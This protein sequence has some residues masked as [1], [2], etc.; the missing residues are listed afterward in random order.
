MYK[1]HED[2]NL[3]SHMSYMWRDSDKIRTAS[4][5]RGMSPPITFGFLHSSCVSLALDLPRPSFTL[6]CSSSILFEYHM[7]HRNFS[8]I[9]SVV[10]SR[11]G[12]HN[13]ARVLWG[14]STG[15]GEVY[16]PEDFCVLIG[17]LE[18][19]VAAGTPSA[20]ACTN[21]EPQARSFPLA[22]DHIHKQPLAPRL[23]AQP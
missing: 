21:Q 4:Q 10:C 1:H 14:C 23:S 18:A 11:R 15:R 22:H 20:P 13:A 7:K 12:Y 19:L 2:V 8:N 3:I 6:N 17:Q 9:Y 16:C 5:A